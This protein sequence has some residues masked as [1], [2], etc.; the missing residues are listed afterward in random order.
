MNRYATLSGVV[1]A[2]A[3]ASG[4][5]QAQERLLGEIILVGYSFCPNP[6]VEADGRLLRIDSNGP[7]YS[8]Y[9]T[10]FGG[11]GLTT[12]ALPDLRG[13]TPIHLGEGPGLSAYGLGEKGGAETR[14]LDAAQLP[15]HAHGA[16]GRLH[17]LN[18]PASTPSPQGALPA[19]STGAAIYGVAP[20]GGATVEMG[21]QAVTV[22]VESAGEGQPVDVRQPYQVLRF[23]IMT[24]GI[25]PS[26]P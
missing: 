8:I 6:S 26:R 10:T 9:G 17:G 19:L 1:A 7:L 15:P 14:V 11:D 2:L 12:F 3:L 18:S 13:R 20:P 16:T 23:C 21:P 4:A 5:A 25:F 22:A 24:N